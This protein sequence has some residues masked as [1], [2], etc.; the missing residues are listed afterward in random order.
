MASQIAIWGAQ[1]AGLS[2][3]AAC[4]Q[5]SDRSIH[6]RRV[7]PL[8]SRFFEIGFVFWPIVQ[9]SWIEVCARGPHKRV[10]L[11]I[12][13]HPR[14]FVWVVQWTEEFAAK[15]WLEIN[16]TRQTIIEPDAQGVGPCLFESDYSVDGMLHCF[17]LSQRFD[18]RRF[19]PA[20]KHVPIC[21]Q[22]FLMQFCPRVY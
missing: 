13:L 10:Y 22:L 1:A 6:D 14:E 5:P 15:N 18:S 12:D 21:Q 7:L 3:P 19:F 20:P 11:R 8:L 9:D 2:L 16:R 17:I 4:W